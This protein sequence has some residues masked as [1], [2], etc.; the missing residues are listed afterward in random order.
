[1]ANTPPIVR[2][3]RVERR[4]IGNAQGFSGRVRFIAHEDSSEDY[5]DGEG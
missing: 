3:D 4:M 1:M 2:M 5:S